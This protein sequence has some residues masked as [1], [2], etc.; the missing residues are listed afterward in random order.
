MFRNRPGGSVGNVLMEKKSI[1]KLKIFENCRLW[2]KLCYVRVVSLGLV[3]DLWDVLMNKMS[4]YHK[5]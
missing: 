1:E 4:Q 5:I 2:S 3:L